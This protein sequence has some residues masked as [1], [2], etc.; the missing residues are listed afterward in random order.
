MNL[1]ERKPVILTIY[2]LIFHCKVEITTTS[3]VS[4]AQLHAQQRPP[5]TVATSQ[6]K[7]AVFMLC[8]PRNFSL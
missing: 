5:S 6:P 2:L 7:C 3:Y 1:H 8:T 4:L